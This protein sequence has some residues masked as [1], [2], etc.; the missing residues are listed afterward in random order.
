MGKA[1]PPPPRHK[2]KS[3]A[4]SKWKDWHKG[5]ATERIKRYSF[6]VETKDGPV[7]LEAAFY[8]PHTAFAIPSW[9]V[10]ITA[11]RISEGKS[12]VIFAGVYPA[13]IEAEDKAWEEAHKAATALK[14][15]TA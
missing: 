3:P 13:F 2:S 4:P 1:V 5:T 11:Y 15:S 14:H 12:D 8:L 10:T 6:R 9:I 7:T